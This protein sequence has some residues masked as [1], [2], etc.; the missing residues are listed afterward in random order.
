MKVSEIVRALED[1]RGVVYVCGLGGICDRLSAL[2]TRLKAEPWV[3]AEEALAVVNEQANDEAL[4]FFN[5]RTASEAY[6]QQSLRRLHAAVEHDASLR[7]KVLVEGW[8]WD[9][10]HNRQGEISAVRFSETLANTPQ[11]RR[12]RIVAAPEV[13]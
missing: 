8:L 4:W 11:A 13:E 2:I 9:I 6:L 12:V 7:P 10:Q 3:L 5:N 1:I